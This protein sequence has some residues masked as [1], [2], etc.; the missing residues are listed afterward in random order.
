MNNPE[1]QPAAPWDILVHAWFALG[2]NTPPVQWPV[3]D[4]IG[5]AHVLY[6]GGVDGLACAAIDGS[7]GVRI[8]RMHFYHNDDDIGTGWFRLADGKTTP[9][10][11]PALWPEVRKP[12]D[13]PSLEHR[14]PWQTL[15]SGDEVASG[16][17]YSGEKPKSGL[18]WLRADG[19]VLV[20]E[21]LYRF[22]LAIPGTTQVVVK[23][24]G[25][26]WLD[27]P[28]LQVI[29][30]VSGKTLTCQVPAG[31]WK[32]VYWETQRGCMLLEDMEPDER[33]SSN[34][35][36]IAAE[37][38]VALALGFGLRPAKI[39]RLLWLDP[40]TGAVTPATGDPTPLR[41]LDRR[42]LQP[43]LG[44][45]GLVWATLP[46]HNGTRIGHYNPAQLSFTAVAQV[47]GLNF[48]SQECWVDEAGDRLLISQRGDLLMVPLAGLRLPIGK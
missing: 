11:R 10:H 7:D 14:R 3:L 45:E 40:H 28:S 22:P 2:K 33:A 47:D 37:N 27:H 16:G 12:P 6:D 48:S 44:R 41:D 17:D 4:T 9:C 8:L 1:T 15:V 29:D 5:G 23:T 38:E 21:G 25:E 13:G 19:P 35:P 36:A 30:C 39:P 46:Q 31:D 20:K 32:P 42:P 43:V 18:W 34:D 26:F 24:A